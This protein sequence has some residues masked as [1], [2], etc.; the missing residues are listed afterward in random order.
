MKMSQLTFFELSL[1]GSFCIIDQK[2][3]VMSEEEKRKF[4]EFGEMIK[5]EILRRDAS[6]R[7]SGSTCDPATESDS[8]VGEGEQ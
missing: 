2:P 7:S 8:T 5:K 1:V 3:R 4:V 6:S